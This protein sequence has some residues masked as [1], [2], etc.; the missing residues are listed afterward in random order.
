M[1]PESELSLFNSSRLDHFQSQLQSLLHRIT[2][3]ELLGQFQQDPVSQQYQLD[4][5]RE[6]IEESLN[7]EQEATLESLMKTN[8]FLKSEIKR[9][10]DDL[11]LKSD[12]I[13]EY[14]QALLKEQGE[15]DRQKKILEILERE[16]KAFSEKNRK[17]AENQAEI[18]EIK[19]QQLNYEK[20]MFMQEI[21]ALKTEIE[22]ANEKILGLQGDLSQKEEKIRKLTTE[23][24]A[25]HAK[26]SEKIVLC[27]EIEGL[28]KTLAEKN[29]EKTN[30][31][32]HFNLRSQDFEGQLARKAAELEDVR[33]KANDKIAGLKDKI[34]EQEIQ[35]DELTLAQ[36]TLV[37]KLQREIDS[38]A[39]TQDRLRKILEEMQE[40]E[41]K[42]EISKEKSLQNEDMKIVR[43]EREWEDRLK[44]LE[45]DLTGSFQSEKSELQAKIRDFQANYVSISDLLK[46]QNDFEKTLEG[47]KKQAQD[48]VSSYEA[49][50]RKRSEAEKGIENELQKKMIELEEKEEALR[51][52]T[53]ENS[54]LKTELKDSKTTETKLKDQR[55]KT[56]NQ[57]LEDEK[58]D[59]QR[60]SKEIKAKNQ[61]IDDLLSNVN[62]LKDKIRVLNKEKDDLSTEKSLLQENR[63][64]FESKMLSWN[65][66]KKSLEIELNKEKSQVSGLNKEIEILRTEIKEKDV[67]LRKMQEKHMEELKVL[68]QRTLDENEERFR[69][70]ERLRVSNDKF[71]RINKDFIQQI[72]QKDSERSQM[73]EKINEMDEEL[74]KTADLQANNF[75]LKDQITRKTRGLN[76]IKRK[77]S[78]I[79]GFL[80]NSKLS[81]LKTNFQAFAKGIKIALETFQ[82]GLRE[83]F[84]SAETKINVFQRGINKRSEESQLFFNEALKKYEFKLQKLSEQFQLEIESLASKNKGFEGENE[85]LGQRNREVCEEKSRIIE[86]LSS[87][88]E[89]NEELKRKIIKQNEEIASMREYYN[90]AMGE[91]SSQQNITKKTIERIR[92]EMQS[93]LTRKVR[94]LEKGQ[95]KELLA[96]NAKLKGLKE[97]HI[98]ILNGLKED[99]DGMRKESAK[100]MNKELD[101][102]THE[103]EELKQKYVDHFFS[104]NFYNFSLFLRVTKK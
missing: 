54:L 96:I 62:K 48:K 92:H 82:G 88:S 34:K 24:T 59:N 77:L 69:E 22:R 41:R 57:A 45:K 74:K 6:V 5:I 58:R 37:Q 17:N 61:E 40:K 44:G 33:N 73:A 71:E 63:L 19:E 1:D 12:E 56:E 94:E 13:S 78:E 93:L 101:L 85:R 86:K 35:I 67:L 91:F 52:L 27:K 64:E 90:S 20:S 100:G 76:E 18:L 60:L 14:K 38:H 3:D 23:N 80:A 29:Q 66:E 84:R 8:I 104:F 53:Q 26:T 89:E 4:R 79:R 81:S 31:E 2:R 99:V 72:R 102:R 25:L 103:I 16:N 7:L 70:I 10:E 49:E 83:V 87:F 55:K 65:H 21:G 68:N 28:K 75:K 15:K 9:L 36:S 50:L 30:N 46:K 43:L 42:S 97:S 39:I 95:K 51:D 11:S 98:D 47:I 32:G